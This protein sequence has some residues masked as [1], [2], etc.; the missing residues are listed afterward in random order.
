MQPKNKSFTWYVEHGYYYSGGNKETLEK[1]KKILQEIQYIDDSILILDDIID[2]SQKRN[3][4]LCLYRKI[5]IG[6][7]IIESKILQT[8]AIEGM[9]TLMKK[10]W[11]KEENQIKIIQ[12]INN[13]IKDIYEWEKLQG[14]TVEEYIKKIKKITW[15]HI[16]CGLRIGQLLFNKKPQKE[17]EEIAT[18][19]WVIRQICD[20]I[21]DYYPWH[22]EPFNDFLSEE[23]RIPE[24]LFENEGWNKNEITILIKNNKL[25]DARKKVINKKVQKQLKALCDI[26]YEKIISIKSNFQYGPL[27]EEYKKIIYQ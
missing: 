22:H 18:S 5:G 26:E 24:I 9:F 11:T 20:D 10:L 3:K 2:K 23:K 19:L 16:K 17:I 13:L 7:T 21:Q 14:T 4:D 8:K 15:S 12:A 25:N 27:L 6:N 1:H